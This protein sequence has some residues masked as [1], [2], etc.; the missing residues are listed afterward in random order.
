MGRKSIRKALEIK[1]VFLLFSFSQISETLSHTTSPSPP[2]SST[3]NLRRILLGVLFGSLTGGFASI[4]F[5]LSIRFFVLFANRIPILDGPVTFSSKISVKT[6]KSVISDYS[7]SPQLLGSNPNGKYLK[8]VLDNQ[9]TVA[10]KMMLEPNCSKGSPRKN[11][12]PWKREVQR[13]LELLAKVNHRNVMSLRAYIRDS[14]RLSL[15][16]DYIPNGS[17]DDAMKRLRSD[18]LLF[19]W[20]LRHR[21]AVGIVKGLKYLHFECTPRILHYDLKPS[22]VLLDEN[23]EPKLADCGLAR[24]VMASLD[25]SVSSCYVAPE[26]FQSCRYTDKCD[27]YSFGVI[28]SFLLTG[29]DP[30][31][32]FFMGVSG[33]GSLGRWLR[34]LQHAGE[35]Q[36]A[37]DK[38]TVGEGD[39]EEMLMAIRIALVCQSDLPA[40]R[41][42]SDELEAMLTQLHSF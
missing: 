23:F 15:V 19:G 27:I 35:A 37:L 28:L 26:C 11:L 6:L 1:S 2:S 13:E 3:A 22:N 16:Y 41:P 4:V 17:L 39:E 42:S 29:R 31:D 21:I 8:F 24:L 20:E 10:V 32:P 14:D 12:G 34:H 25:T 30:S 18:K 40:D 9:L 7:G 33:R 38:K 36:E 5:L